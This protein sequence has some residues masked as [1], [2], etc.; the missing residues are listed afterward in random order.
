[1]DSTERGMNPVAMTII[2]H[3]KEY[4][5][6]R[7]SNKSPPVLKSRLSYGARRIKSVSI[8]MQEPLKGLRTAKSKQLGGKLQLNLPLYRIIKTESL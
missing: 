1:M 7:G 6:S 4:R 2:I 5:P 3:W 8:V